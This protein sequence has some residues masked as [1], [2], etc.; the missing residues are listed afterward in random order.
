MEGILNMEKDTQYRD[1]EYPIV[2]TEDEANEFEEYSELTMAIR[3][4]IDEMPSISLTL[5]LT[6]TS[7]SM[8]PNRGQNHTQ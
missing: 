5:K 1:N 6:L 2:P 7:W 3:K 8:Q 4:K